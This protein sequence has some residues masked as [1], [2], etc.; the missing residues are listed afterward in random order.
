MVLLICAIG[1]SLLVEFRTRPG[2]SIRLALVWGLIFVGAVAAVGLWKDLR[3]DVAPQTVIGPGGRM[4]VPL[5]ESGH[6]Q[7]T[8]D[9]NGEPI[10]FVVDTGA[11]SMALSR[12][13]ARRAGI[14]LDA[15]AFTGEARTANGVVGTASVTLRSVSLGGVTDDDVP[16]VVIGGDLDQSL[17]GMSFLRRF[18]RVTIEGDQ[19]VL[20]R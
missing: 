14:D 20:E 17:M 16:A 3:Q 2:K 12:S 13:D 5:D 4:E 18:A 7:L 6:A 1:G 19:L 9:V 15:L 8:A 11:T 10:R